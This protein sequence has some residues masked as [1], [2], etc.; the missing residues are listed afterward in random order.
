MYFLVLTLIL[1]LTL[2]HFRSPILMLIKE[3][4][5]L[6]SKFDRAKYAIRSNNYNY[7]RNLPKD[8]F[9]Y[10]NYAIK[11]QNIN[12]C[13]ELVQNGFILNKNDNINN[14]L[15]IALHTKN[16]DLV[17]I[18]LND[19]NSIEKSILIQSIKYALTLQ[20]GEILE[21][22]IK[23]IDIIDK[24]DLNSLVLIGLK[25]KFYDGVKILIDNFFDN[26]K[27]NIDPEII[28]MSQNDDNLE[29]NKYM[30]DKTKFT[31]KYKESKSYEPISSAIK[32]NNLQLIKYLFLKGYLISDNNYY[33]IIWLV[34]KCSNV[35]MFEIVLNGILANKNINKDKDYFSLTNEKIL[36]YLEENDKFEELKTLISLLPAQQL[37]TVMT[38]LKNIE[39][40]KSFLECLKAKEEISSK[41][42]ECLRLAVSCRNLEVVK[43]LLDNNIEI[44]NNEHS[45]INYAIPKLKIVKILLEY[46]AKIINDKIWSS[47]NLAIKTKQLDVVKILLKY[48]A[49]MINDK[50]YSS[51]N[52]A[53]KTK[54]FN[55]VKI[56]LEYGAEIIN[57]KEYSSLNLAINT[58]RSDVV[59]ILLEYGAEI[60]KDKEY[61]PI[62]IA[63]KNYNIETLETL[64]KYGCMFYD[65]NNKHLLNDMK[66]YGI[67]V[68]NMMRH[69]IAHYIPINNESNNNNTLYRV[70]GDY[71][72]I[73]KYCL[74]LID[75]GAKLPDCDALKKRIFYNVID[76]D[77]VTKYFIEKG[78]GEFIVECDWNEYCVCKSL[79]EYL[80]NTRRYD[81]IVN[82]NISHDDAHKNYIDAA[83]IML[84][85][86]VTLFDNARTRNANS[87]VVTYG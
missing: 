66:L 74:S 5:R 54:Q 27:F 34:A 73:G 45:I 77:V 61:N 83:K 31:I 29:I 56:L 3:L 42:Q 39:F 40:I 67:H 50:E 75:R 9:Q 18:I 24:S 11:Q 36:L 22:L 84:K 46:G 68:S 78:H 60:M 13:K 7:I 53:I 2:T 52:L 57:D 82:S 44:I 87:I 80:F 72:M 21:S 43:Y 14:S 69:L 76:D 70:L 37:I 25:N 35:Q 23:S 48:G 63:I 41:P 28:T 51:L 26:E 86:K 62:I 79:V 6:Y 38:K 10:V 15:Y 71:G 81:M 59:K 20:F 4:Y 19:I 12:M 65:D 1:T 49:K 17:K 33:D 47:L 64:L 85:R 32:N 8:C 16:S 30:I 58:K 55:V